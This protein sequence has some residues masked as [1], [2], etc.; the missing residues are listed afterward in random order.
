MGRNTE[1]FCEPDVGFS[2]NKVEEIDG[3]PGKQI[4]I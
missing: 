2:G 1:N 4:I 3:D